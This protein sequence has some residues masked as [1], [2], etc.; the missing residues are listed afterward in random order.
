[1]NW[2]CVIFKQPFA[3][4]KIGCPNAKYDTDIKVIKKQEV[5]RWV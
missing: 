3:L 2:D 4:K 1:M 5:A